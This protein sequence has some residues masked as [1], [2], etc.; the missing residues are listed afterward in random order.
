VSTLVL[1]YRGYGRCGGRPS[2]T[3][4]VGDAVQFFDWLAGRPEVDPTRIV[5]QGASLGG[6]VAAALAEQ[7][8]P[9][10][11]V[12]E[13]TF[14]SMP[15]LAH[16]YGLPGFLCRNP[17]ETDRILPT[18]HMPIAIYHGRSDRR[19]SVAHGRRLHALV[20]GSRYTELPCGHDDFRN[21]WANVRA[22][23]VEAGVLRT[24]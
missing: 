4:L 18:L 1:E 14:A 20:P 21:D 23:L 16:Q 2:Q 10:A 6:A 24:Q 15:A 7:R 9:A 8:R 17:F 5:F 19:I 11:L 3:A 13:R 22:F 12:L